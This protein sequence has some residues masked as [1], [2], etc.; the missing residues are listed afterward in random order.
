[1][2]LGLFLLIFSLETSL[3]P[4]GDRFPDCGFLFIVS[5]QWDAPPG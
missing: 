5:E 4:Q 3:N 2:L 1:M